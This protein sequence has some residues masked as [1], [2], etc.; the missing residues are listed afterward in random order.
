MCITIFSTNDKNIHANDNSHFMCSCDLIIYNYIPLIFILYFFN[1]SKVPEWVLVK[2]CRIYL[3]LKDMS[4]LSC[5][6]ISS[7]FPKTLIKK[8]KHVKTDSNYC[9]YSWHNLL[10]LHCTEAVQ[11]LTGKPNLLALLH[12]SYCVNSRVY[13]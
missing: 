4:H 11:I 8:K 7:S 3:S 5:T 12:P 13:Q 1:C 10:C 9:L 6:C 2:I